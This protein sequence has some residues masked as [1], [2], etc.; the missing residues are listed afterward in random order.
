VNF[1]VLI[2][3]KIDLYLDEIVMVLEERAAFTEFLSDDSVEIIRFPRAIPDTASVGVDGHP[4]ATASAAI[5]A[6]VT[7][8]SD[9]NLSKVVAFHYLGSKETTVI[10]GHEVKFD[11]DVVEHVEVAE[12]LGFG[13]PSALPVAVSQRQGGV[14]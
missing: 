7:A 11:S 3:R 8:S 1:V 6:A 10:L 13:P 2:V 4:I 5:S 9:G 12:L 14:V